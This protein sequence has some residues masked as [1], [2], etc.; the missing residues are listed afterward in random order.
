MDTNVI[1][2]EGYTELQQEL[3]YLWRKERPEVTKKVQWAASLGDRSENADYQYNKKRLR[4]IDRR[5]RYLRNRLSKLRIVNYSP[6]QEGKAF[7]GAWVT[8]ADESDDKL[9]FRI[10]GPDEIYGKKHYVSV[11]APVVKACL[12]KSVG[13]EIVVRT[14]ESTKAW[15]IVLIN[16][17]VD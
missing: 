13:D 14:P 5:V 2:P 10:V 12:G 3:D 7:F 16:Y 17:Q 8:L 6:V 9:T 15:E 4:E 1:T 11:H